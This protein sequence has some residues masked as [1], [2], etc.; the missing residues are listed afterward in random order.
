MTQQD[1]EKIRPTSLSEDVRQREIEEFSRRDGKEDALSVH[2]R[3]I[4]L[5]AEHLRLQRLIA[6]LLME[7]QKLRA[8]HSD[9]A[10]SSASAATAAVCERHHASTERMHNTPR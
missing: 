5:E 7:N 9:R 6:E 10:G 2:S 3:L 4:E 1:M 8:L